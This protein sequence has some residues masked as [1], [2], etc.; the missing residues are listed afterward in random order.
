MRTNKNTAGVSNITYYNANGRIERMFRN[1]TFRLHWFN[2]NPGLDWASMQKRDQLSSVKG[3]KFSNLE[4]INPVGGTE[5]SILG[6]PMTEGFSD[7]Q[8]VNPV[9][10][11]NNINVSGLNDQSVIEMA[12]RRYKIGND[13]APVMIKVDGAWTVIGIL[14]HT[15][16]SDRD[17]VTPIANTN[18]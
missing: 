11:K 2:T 17:V 16:S 15:D 18:K 10:M 9:L 4:S 7:S 5:T 6:Y 1:D 8:V 13:G 14:G 12:S 3:L